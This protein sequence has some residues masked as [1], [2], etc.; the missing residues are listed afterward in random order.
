VSKKLQQIVVLSRVLA[1]EV[2]V[3][4]QN[5]KSLIVDKVND[6]KIKDLKQL[7]SIVKN[8]KKGFIVFQLK[9]KTKIVFDVEKLRQSTTSIMD[10]YRIPQ[11]RSLN[12]IAKPE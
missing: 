8:T 11:D 10:R 12:L 5:L 1:A 6:K 4:Y 2:N 9:N 3:G 7:I